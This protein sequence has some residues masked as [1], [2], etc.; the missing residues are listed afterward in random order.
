MYNNYP[1]GSIGEYAVD[2]WTYT[3]V[4][5]PTWATDFMGYC[6]NR[7]VSPYTYLA[8]KDQIVRNTAAI[9]FAAAF[10]G[11]DQQFLLLRLRVYFD[12]RLIFQPGYIV[13]NVKPT[14]EAPPRKFVP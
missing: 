9:Q 6:I 13:T 12:G 10:E 5:P 11:T 2:M 8:L 7:W 1:S 4:Y 14:Q 3:F